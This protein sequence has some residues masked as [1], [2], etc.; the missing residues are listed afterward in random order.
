MINFGWLRIIVA[1]FAALLVIHL[2]GS[3]SSSKFRAIAEDDF[4]S[5]PSRT[6]LDSSTG[7]NAFVVFLATNF[8]SNKKLD[9][10]ENEDHYFIGTRMLIYQLLHD[11]ETCTNTSIPLVVLVTSDV[12]Q[13]NRE[14]LR[15][16][17]AQVMEADEI[18]FGWIK[19]RRERWTHV[20]D[21]LYAFKLTQFDKVLLLDADIVVT[22]R[23]DSIFDDLAAQ[24]SANLQMPDEIYSDEAPQP[25]SYIM[26]GS[27]ERFEKDRLNAGFVILK[28]SKEIFELYLSV[29][30]TEGKFP[31]TSP[32]QDLWNYV[33]NPDGN[34]PWKQ[35]DPGWA[36]NLPS[37]H[38]Y[39]HGIATLHEKYWKMGVDNNLKEVLLKSRWKMEGFFDGYH[40]RA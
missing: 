34:M 22:K 15:K 6:S 25:S 20:M 5:A 12:S 30:K 23:L 37:W 33:H 28:P 17:G 19:P 14:Q 35:I 18:K 31:G 21:K 11:P 1:V 29:G 4:V 26:A 24:E 2:A 32:E 36:L 8:N 10:L 7:R 16:D 27:S 3:N 40:R 39:N 9:G 38:D 13:A